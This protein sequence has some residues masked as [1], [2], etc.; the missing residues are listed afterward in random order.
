M[1][2]FIAGRTTTTSELKQV[3]ESDFPTITICMDPP[4]KPSVTPKFGLNWAWDV[5]EKGIPDTAMPNTTLVEKL[6]TLSYVMDKDF[7]IKIR[8]KN[9][10]LVNLK[11]GNNIRFAIEPVFTFMKGI[12]YK[13][14]PK[15]KVTSQYIPDFTFQIEFKVTDEDVP[16][17]F[18]LYLT[19][20]DATLSIAT[21]IWAQY[22]PGTVKFPSNSTKFS[23]IT[24]D[25]AIQ[26]NFKTGVG[27]SSECMAK[28]MEESQC[29]KCYY[30]S[31]LPLC[32]S[33]E[34]FEC[35]WGSNKVWQKCL[36]Q[37]HPVAYLP[38]LNEYK[39]YDAN[40]STP[41]VFM[42]VAMTDTIQIIEEI[43]IITLSGL[44]GSIGGSLGMFF[45][46]SITPYLSFLIEKITKTIFNS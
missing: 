7:S 24:Y 29:N 5:Y 8:S 20:P 2:D 40:F 38:K 12:C 19:S 45:G 25:R 30:T 35:L 26:Y 39:A 36:L 22:L 27:N 41:G 13:M 18:M 43:D 4:L 32:D 21:E 14:E 1:E 17:H 10:S 6:E 3:E 15:F 46:F 9:E 11:V 37:K 16:S 23:I 33:M 44:I 28:V 31:S 34:D 42:I